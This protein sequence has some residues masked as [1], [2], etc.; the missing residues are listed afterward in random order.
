MGKTPNIPK[1]ALERPHYPGRWI[2]QKDAS[3]C[4]GIFHAIDVRKYLCPLA[5]KCLGG[6][7]PDGQL[8]SIWP[9]SKW[10]RLRCDPTGEH[11]RE[12][13]KRA[14][15]LSAVFHREER[16]VYMH[17]YHI[18]HKDRPRTRTPALADMLHGYVPLNAAKVPPPPCGGDHD[19]CPYNG[20]CR[21]PNWDEEQSRVY[22]APNG[23][24]RNRQALRRKNKAY[25]ERRNERRK[26]DPELDAKIKADSRRKGIKH[27][28][29]VKFVQ[30]GGSPERFEMLWAKAGGTKE[31]WKPIWNDIKAKGR[32]GP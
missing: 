13:D 19:N 8:E 1:E 26:S 17:K 31:Q 22:V 27:Y 11:A 9:R 29:K 3:K 12:H 10:G 21:Y 30:L 32:Y 6:K 15:E 16:T 20:K 24:R 23:G 14:K 25:R 2:C 28:Y 4:N 18:T 7:Y 5:G